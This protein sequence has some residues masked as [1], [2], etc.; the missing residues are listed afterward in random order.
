MTTPNFPPDRA[1]RAGQLKLNLFIYPNGH[2]EAAWRHPQSTPERAM[3]VR[4]YQ[5]LAQQAERAKFDAIFFADSPTVSHDLRL[6]LRGRFEPLTWLSAIAAVTSHIGLIATASTTYYE[7]YNLARLFNSL[8]H[9]SD[10]RA[11]W[12]IVTTSVAAASANFGQQS[13]A[14][15][16]ERY[17]RAQEFM[18]VVTG[19][20]DSWEDDALVFD[21]AGGVFADETKVHAIDHAGEHYRVKGP[22]NAPRSPQGRPVY[23]QAGS[24]EDGREFAARHAEVIFTAHQTIDSALEFATDIRR[25]ATAAGRD[26]AS[27]K[28][29]PGIS[30]F[31]GATDADAQR[32]QDELNAL[33]Q[34]DFSL[35]TLHR[36]L[37]VDI[38]ACDLDA[39]FPRHLVDFDA[40]QAQTSRFQLVI[41]I[42]DRERPTLRG[43]IN[44]MAG[45]RGHW[46]PVGTPEGIADLMQEWFEAG[47]A[48]G[49]NVMPPLLPSGLERFIA[50]VVPVLR[51]RGL[52]REEYEG[53]TLRSHYGLER[54][55]SGYAR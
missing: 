42:V 32:Q 13:H 35:D 27:L 2:H 30:A 20:W 40:P 46:V 8:D 45:A 23:V 51:R 53:A 19:L 41:G 9:L 47:A 5:K 48:D 17:R 6:G 52:F 16:H 4:Y 11:G 39:P 49:F 28:I 25:R 54:P 55:A 22:F 14:A 33:L 29:L 44:R 34:T 21:K 1:K 43:L 31:I 18:D 26:P 50:D 38:S 37:G 36:L 24:S 3:D 15:P 10:G 7:P 12:N